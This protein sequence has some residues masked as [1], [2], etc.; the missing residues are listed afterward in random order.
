MIHDPSDIVPIKLT[1][2]PQYR[3]MEKP[4]FYAV[5]NY[6]NSSGSYESDVIILRYNATTDDF[7][8]HQRLPEYAPTELESFSG[9]INPAMHKNFLSVAGM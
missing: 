7:S 1:L 4:K 2:D 3:M 9:K 6:R 8:V 5:A